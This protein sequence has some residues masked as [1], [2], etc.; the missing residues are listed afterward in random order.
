MR[1]FAKRR[2][3]FLVLAATVL[4]LAAAYRPQRYGIWADQMTYYLQADSIAFDGDLQFDRRDLARFR[5]HGWKEKGPIGLFLREAN[6]RFY[7]SKPF[8]Y[9]LAAVPFV[10]IAPVRGPIVLNALLWLFLLEIT[11]RWYRRRNGAVR[12][13]TIAALAWIGSAAPFYI[14]VIHTDLMIPALLGAGLYLWL[15]SGE[16]GSPARSESTDVRAPSGDGSS[17]EGRR[18]PWRILLSGIFFGL[19][20]YEKNPLVFFL[21]AAAGSLCARREFRRAGLMVAA[22][23]F[24]F[25]LPTSV[26]LAQD[27]H[28]SPYQGR[29]IYCNGDFPFDNLDK[30]RAS[31]ARFHHPGSEFFEPRLGRT[32]FSAEHLRRFASSLPAKVGFYFVGRKTGLFPYLTPAL[33]ALILWLGGLVRRERSSTWIAAALA[34]YVIFYFFVLSAYYGGATAIGNRYALQV[35]PAFLFLVGRFPR[36]RRGFAA[37]AGLL[38]GAALFFPGYDL[39]SPY[40]KVRDNLDLFQ[41]PRFRWLPFEWNLAWFMADKTSAVADLGTVGKVLRLTDMNPTFD[42]RGYFLSGRR[43]DVALLTRKPMERI[44]VRLAARSR[45]CEGRIL[46]GKNRARFSLEPFE[47]KIV[48]IPLGLRGHAF[49]RRFDVYCYIISFRVETPLE[50]DTIYPEGYYKQLG[51]FLR[52]LGDA[53]PPSA[54]TAVV[55]DEPACAADLLWGWHAPE[56]PQGSPLRTRWAGEAM[57]SA[58]VVAGER[59]R[60]CILEIEAECPTVE[61]VECLWNGRRLGKRFLGPGKADLRF[62]LPAA[63][64][65]AGGNVLVLRHDWLWQPSVLFGDSATGDSRSLAVHYRRIALRE[66][67]KTVA[68]DHNSAAAGPPNR[69]Q[70]ARRKYFLFPLTLGKGGR[71]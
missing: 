6:G 9:S 58:V 41:K 52:W 37:M 33:A 67:A 57:E 34:A 42:E 54:S 45:R 1:G 2:A 64:V 40:G 31:V 3:P 68:A 59:P 49:Y 36:E 17:P 11:H 44:A 30:A 32:L 66:A 12:A 53:P 22:A 29:R 69:R 28:F 15:T 27:G 48:Q 16:A 63:L 5:S 25:L 56:P 35:L 46:S 13:A 24:A 38:A 4:A 19:A 20:V 60:D 62:P 7:Y 23:L 21:A 47:T 70:T 50:A 71:E 39:F 43:H 55:P 65:R 18:S 10:W 61:G 8:L 26:H 51:P 14:F